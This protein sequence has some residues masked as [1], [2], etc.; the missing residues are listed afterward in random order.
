MSISEEYDRAKKAIEYEN[1]PLALADR[2]K[3]TCMLGMWRC[4][5]K[6]ANNQK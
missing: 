4:L 5:V 1:N 6:I 2:F 3:L